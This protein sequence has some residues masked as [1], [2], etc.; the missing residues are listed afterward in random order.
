V[1]LRLDRI[2]IDLTGLDDCRAEE[3]LR[4]YA[5]YSSETTGAETGALRVEVG[6]ED[7]D[8][9]IEPP[10][11]PE[12]NPVFLAVDGDRVRYVGYKVAGWF[13]S[14]GE[15]GRLLLARGT[16]EPDVRSFENYIRVAVAWRAATLGGAL[17]HAASAVRDGRAY[18]F[19]GES[20]AGKSTLAASTRRATIV[21]DDLSL[22]LPD[23]R[24]GL[25]LVGSPFRGTFEGG[26]PVQGSFPVAAG[27]RLI[28]AAEPEVRTVSR[29]RAMAEL[30]A[31]LPFVAE[32][33]GTKRDLLEGIERAF[34]SIPLAHLRFR[35]DDSYW[36]AI[37]RAG[38]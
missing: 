15:T 6:L 3:L 24:G 11:R 2:R 22:V 29:P 37:D 1:R 26:S 36:D 33:S 19:Y 34:A 30:V 21:S 12:L 5:P 38:L 9:F 4:R 28:Q 10:P 27:F 25:M 8:Y 32:A 7:R 13:D 20:G 31:N 17:V 35:K 18:L 14:R 23:G 16:Y